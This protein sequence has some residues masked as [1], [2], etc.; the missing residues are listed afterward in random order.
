M[1]LSEV[2]AWLLSK[3]KKLIIKMADKNELQRQ[4]FLRRI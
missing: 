1:G 2:V 3:L 4:T